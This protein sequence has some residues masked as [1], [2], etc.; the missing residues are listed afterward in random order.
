[1]KKKTEISH[2][3]TGSRVH[4]CGYSPLIVQLANG[5]SALFGS[6]CLA[7]PF[8]CAATC[9][10]LGAYSR[11]QRV[12]ERSCYICNESGRQAVESPYRCLCRNLQNVETCS[13]WQ[14]QN[15]ESRRKPKS[16]EL[17][18]RCCI[19]ISKYRRI[20]SVPT[21]VGTFNQNARTLH[22]CRH[23]V[24]A[25]WSIS[26]NAKAVRALRHLSI[27]FGTSGAVVP[28]LHMIYTRCIR[29]AAEDFI[30]EL[31]H[32]AYICALLPTVNKFNSFK[33]CPYALHHILGCIGPVS[34]ISTMYY[35]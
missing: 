27:Y 22:T 26:D 28:M 5:L 29:P 23:G 8:H 2:L 20:Y 10:S 35:V 30:A 32:R 3:Q 15:V 25:S 16:L 13:N 19:C 31:C 12:I 9:I 11:Q 7:E 21:V 33:R 34:G 6:R 1:M 14:D 17:Q 24:L 4:L 18:D